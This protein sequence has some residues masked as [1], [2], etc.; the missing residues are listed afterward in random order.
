MNREC[1]LF[2]DD[3]R[4]LIVVSSSFSNEATSSF[5]DRYQ[6]SESLPINS[7]VHLEDY[8]LHLIDIFNGR[9]SDEINFKYDKIYIP[10]NHGIY[11]YKNLLSILSVQHQTIY[12]YYILSSGKFVFT[13]KIG[14]FCMENDAYIYTRTVLN[15]NKK[16]MNWR[17]SYNVF[18]NSLKHRLLVFLFKR[19]KQLSKEMNSVKPIQQFYRDFD[20]YVK[21]RI[22]KLQLIDDEHILLKYDLECP[23]RTRPENLKSPN[24]FVIYNWKSAEILNVYYQYSDILLTAYENY[25]DSFRHTPGHQCSPSNNYYARRIYQD[26]KHSIIES[27]FTYK[28]AIRNLLQ[29][30]PHSAQSIT[31]R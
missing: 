8:C 24:F 9:I 25:C 15:N 6:N 27:K 7:R 26:F 22:W 10:H 13:R 28:D 5:R 14:Q 21:L 18:Y 12:L 11:L 17:T 29:F 23:L 19:A 31:T 30:L 20:I 1:S 16:P 4:F 2:T 3:N